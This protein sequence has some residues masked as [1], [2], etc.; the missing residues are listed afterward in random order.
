MTWDHYYD[1]WSTTISTRD[2]RVLSDGRL[3]VWLMVYTSH[4][5][6]VRSWTKTNRPLAF[7]IICT[8]WCQDT[9][10]KGNFLTSVKLSYLIAKRNRKRM[11]HT[12]VARLRISLYHCKIK[13]DSSMSHYTNFSLIL[14]DT[15][16]V[17]FFFT[18][19]IWTIADQKPMVKKIRKKYGK[20]WGGLPS[21]PK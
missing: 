17:I 8:M 18:Q 14:H 16:A 12:T 13:L 5:A 3:G 11:R 4:C 2:L 15:V 10:G 7:E 20:S 21:S 9:K 1:S 19:N 6:T